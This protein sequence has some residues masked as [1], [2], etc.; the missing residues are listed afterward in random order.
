MSY[1][2]LETLKEL[3]EALEL[4]YHEFGNYTR[5][6]DVFRMLDGIKEYEDEILNQ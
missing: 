4:F 3:L 6:H 2:E 5:A 1:E